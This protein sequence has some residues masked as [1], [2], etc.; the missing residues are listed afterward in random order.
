MA[1]EPNVT[2]TVSENQPAEGF[3]TAEESFDPEESPPGEAAEIPAPCSYEES[4]NVTETAD[5]TTAESGNDTWTTPDLRALQYRSGPSLRGSASGFSDQ[6]SWLSL[7][8]MFRCS[9]SK[10]GRGLKGRK[11]P[12]NLLNLLRQYVC[13][14]SPVLLCL[15]AE[16][17]APPMRW[18]SCLATA[19]LEWANR[20][21]QYHS[22]V[23]KATGCRGPAAENICWGHPSVESCVTAW[24]EEVSLWKASPRNGPVPGAGHFT[25]M[26]WNSADKIGCGTAANGYMVCH[27]KGGNAL[28]CNKPNHHD[29]SQGCYAKNIGSRIRTKEQCRGGAGAV[30]SFSSSP[31][32]SFSPAPSPS[33]VSS[34]SSS[35][36]PA[37]P[38]RPSSSYAPPR[39]STTPR[40]YRA[41]SYAPTSSW[42][43]A[44]ASTPVYSSPTRNF[45]PPRVRPA[46]TPVYS[47]SPSSSS[48]FGAPRAG[49]TVYRQTPGS[50][51][52]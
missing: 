48:S 15:C 10:G 35:F 47:S 1:S 33:F 19:A 43:P 18:D 13:F 4:F 22:P 30:S 39:P 44:A 51:R 31:P 2:S 20:G 9:E 41:P 46:S 3:V 42:R 12:I 24:Y 28:D 49:R 34:P 50:I 40:T 27:Y 21:V 6:G 29:P 17:G 7:H 36:T 5:F 52:G 23:D 25:A 32:S 11:M 16:H 38:A 26:I 8:N 14:C 45:S 37:A